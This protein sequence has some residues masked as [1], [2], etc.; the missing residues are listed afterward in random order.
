MTYRRVLTV[1]G[2]GPG[3]GLAVARRHGLTHDYPPSSI[4]PGC[5]LVSFG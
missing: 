5:H 1:A 2:A 4:H 3:V